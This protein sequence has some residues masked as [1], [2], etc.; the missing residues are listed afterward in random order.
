MVSKNLGKSIVILSAAALLLFP[1]PPPSHAEEPGPGLGLADLQQVDDSALEGLRGRY[2]DVY[3]SISFTGYWGSTEAPSANLTYEVGLGSD[4]ST[5]AFTFSRVDDQG[6]ASQ[7]GPFLPSAQPTGDTSADSGSTSSSTDDGVAL[8]TSAVLGGGGGLL[9]TSGATQV[10]QVPGSNNFVYQG[11][12]INLWMIDV[13]ETATAE[14]VRTA[15]S[16]ML[17]LQR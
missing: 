8:K 12:N 2:L 16:N 6:D 4:N 3:F 11:M 9:G 10:T 7:S 1:A 14:S 17:D 5:G 13:R 15:L